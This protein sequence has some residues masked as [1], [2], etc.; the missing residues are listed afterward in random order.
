MSDL[1]VREWLDP[2]EI[3]DEA[4]ESGP[5]L[6][7]IARVRGLRGQEDAAVF[8]AQAMKAG[9]PPLPAHL[10]DRA[11]LLMGAGSHAQE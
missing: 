10:R 4:A 3:L 11:R 8:A 6:L 7:R 5:V 2:A 1:G 9:R